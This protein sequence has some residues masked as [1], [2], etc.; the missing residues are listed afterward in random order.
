M[1]TAQGNVVNI[2]AK[3]AYR[4]VIC[5]G[6]AIGNTLTISQQN[7]VEA[8]LIDDANTVLATNAGGGT[9][10]FTRFRNGD[11]IR[12]AISFLA[13]PTLGFTREADGSL[14]LYSAGV[15]I[16]RW[17]STGLSFPDSRAIV[18]V[19]TNGLKIGT[20]ASQKYGFWGATPIVQPAIGNAASDPATTQTLVNN[21]RTA[22]INAGLAKIS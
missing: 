18:A 19:G 4:S 15:E 7:V 10:N 22:L 6:G 8:P 1:P 20:S 16:C 17:N 11:Y 12:P 21:I 9:G 5:N 3:R 14:R 13:D 2:S